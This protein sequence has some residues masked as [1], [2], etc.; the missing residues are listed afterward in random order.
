MSNPLAGAEVPSVF[1]IARDQGSRNARSLYK[2]LYAVNE[3]V[4]DVYAQA[5][6]AYGRTVYVDAAAD[7]AKATGSGAFPFATIGAA[8]AYI[9]AEG[10]AGEGYVVEIAAGSYTAETLTISRP[11]IHLKGPQAHATQTTYATVGPIVVN[12]TSSAGTPQTT[13]CTLSGLLIATG[14]ADALT[15]SGSVAGTV[16]VVACNFYAEVGYRAVNCTNANARLRSF[17]CEFQNGLSALPTIAWAGFW[18]DVRQANLYPGTGPALAQTAGLAQLDSCV[19]QGVT[20]GSMLTAS[21]SSQLNVSNC[22]IE[23]SAA[24]GNG[25][26]L[27]GTAQLT[28]VQNLFRVPAGTGRCVDGVLGN[29]VVHALNVF[30][31]TYNNKFQT[32]I[33]PGLVAASTTPT[34]A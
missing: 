21:G 33:G 7:A 2:Y 34:L 24:N 3:A 23:P 10:V 28:I 20:G 31:P 25:F 29:V 32:A 15:I 26:V 9:D 30:A 18:L 6:S 17:A 1:E 8:L 11:K 22:Y 16:S 4:G 19:L 13:N 14:S 5:G 12:W 27:S